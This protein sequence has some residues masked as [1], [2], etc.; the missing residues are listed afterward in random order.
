MGFKNFIVLLVP[1]RVW[2]LVVYAAPLLRLRA[3]FGTVRSRI[4]A[5]SC[6]SP[7][8]RGDVSLTLA[9]EALLDGYTLVK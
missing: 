8:A 1:C 5:T 7:A 2:F 3:L 9:I 4:V 6:L